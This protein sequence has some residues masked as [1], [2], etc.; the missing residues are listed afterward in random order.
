MQSNDEEVLSQLMDECQ[1]FIKEYKSGVEV[2]SNLIMS[3][4]YIPSI[5]KRN[6][7]N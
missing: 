7:T 1:E 3:E 2:T 5:T 4:I 6:E